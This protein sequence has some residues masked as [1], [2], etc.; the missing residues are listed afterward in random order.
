MVKTPVFEKPAIISSAEIIPVAIKITAAL[1][2]ITPG[3][4]IPIR[5]AAR[6]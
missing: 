2:R 3:R 5:N 6:M 1:N 4:K